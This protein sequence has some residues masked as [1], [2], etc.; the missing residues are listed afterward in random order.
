[1]NMVL[2]YNIEI[3]Y[4]NKTIYGKFN[5]ITLNEDVIGQFMFNSKHSS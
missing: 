1:M 3:N 5:L 4:K 2:I